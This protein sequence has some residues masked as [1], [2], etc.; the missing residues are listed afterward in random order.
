MNQIA[1]ETID[2]DEFK[3]V[4]LGNVIPCGFIRRGFVRAITPASDITEAAISRSVKPVLV[5]MDF[6][7]SQLCVGI[8][9]SDG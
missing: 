5:P 8:I 6:G 3:V 1:Q 2:D 7:P 9:L 4:S